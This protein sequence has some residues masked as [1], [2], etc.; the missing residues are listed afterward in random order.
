MAYRAL[1]DLT[2][3]CTLFLLAPC[4]QLVHLR[5]IPQN[6]QMHSHLRASL[7]L[8]FPWL[9]GL[10]HPALPGLAPGHYSGLSSNITSLGRSPL[11]TPLSL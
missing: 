5:S 9:P 4:T 6:P 3:S 7:S 11:T 8:Q 1:Y 2:F 10:S